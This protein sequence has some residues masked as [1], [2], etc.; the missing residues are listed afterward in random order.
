[1][2]F[3]ILRNE[4]KAKWHNR[5]HAFEAELKKHARARLPGFACPEWVEI[6]DDLPVSLLC[7]VL[8]GRIMKSCAARKRRRGKSRRSFCDNVLR[9]C[10]ILNLYDV[11][12]KIT[13]H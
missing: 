4:A 9:S 1:M 8:S 2:A 7:Y 11:E 10:S 13:Q 3:V 6:A 12:C 5:H